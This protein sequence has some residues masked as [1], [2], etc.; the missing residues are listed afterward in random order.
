MADGIPQSDASTNPAPPASGGT[1]T[2]PFVGRF[3]SADGLSFGLTSLL[4]LVVYLFTLGPGVSLEFSGELSTAAFYAGVAH[5]AGYPLWTIYS[6]LLTTLLP[7]SNIA[8]RVGV[9]SAIAA[10]LACGTVALMVSSGAKLLM[11]DS[12]HFERLTSQERKWA[13]MVCG[14]VAGMALGMSGA[15]WRKAVIADIWALSLL[16]FVLILCLGFRWMMQ[17]EK[18][19]FLFSQYLLMGLLLTNSQEMIVMLPGLVF[20][21]FMGN[22]ELSRD[23]AL[24]VLAV[25]AI[26]SRWSQFGLWCDFPE[27]GNLPLLGAFAAVTAFG[28][29]L[30]LRTRGF[31]STWRSVCLCNVCLFL[32]FAFC[33]YLPIASMTNPPANWGYPRTIGGFTHV[34]SRGQYERLVPTADLGRF[35]EQLWMLIRMAGEDLGWLYLLFATVPFMCLRRMNQEARSWVFALVVIF[36]CVGPLLVAEINPMTDL[37]GQDLSKFYFTPLFATLSVLSGLGMTLSIPLLGRRA[38]KMPGERPVA[39][40]QPSTPDL[41]S[42]AL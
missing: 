22:R 30:A 12:P 41:S 29:L 37:Q 17:P 4:A 24:T 35:A 36:V 10:A 31:G 27:L 14:Y 23:L 26:L 3:D 7:C 1:A 9:G 32:G 13:R 20:I 40:F 16:L 2:L 39:P 42:S 25:A 19:R 33:L 15:V 8:W 5:P 18:K 6:W 21:A 11:V 28:L 38:P 34:L